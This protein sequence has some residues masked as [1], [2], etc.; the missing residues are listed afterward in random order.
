MP[1]ANSPPA[2]HSFLLRCWQERNHA[3]GDAGVWR[4]SLE[5]SR[6]GKRHG[7]AN[8]E[9][10]MEYLHAALQEDDRYLSSTE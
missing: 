3:A 9:T 8:L 10:L 2:Y 7:F 4:F 6:T 1:I 5:D